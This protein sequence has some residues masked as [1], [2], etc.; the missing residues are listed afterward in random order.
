MKI[1]VI[2]TQEN[3]NMFSI[4]AVHFLRLT[5]AF[6]GRFIPADEIGKRLLK[7]VPDSDIDIGTTKED[8]DKWKAILE[9]ASEQKRIDQ[10]EKV[11]AEKVAV[12][13]G[14]I[15][16]KQATEVTPEPQPESETEID[17]PALPFSKKELDQ[18]DLSQLSAIYNEIF[19]SK[20]IPK[21]K[22][23]IIS[24]ILQ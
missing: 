8:E 10:L 6:K 21:T 5:K 24:E 13:T 12:I 7:E 9:N 19:P 1:N 22:K 15:P 14:K 23:E 17:L 20:K 11:V 2:D 3:N 16:V 18:M 4:E